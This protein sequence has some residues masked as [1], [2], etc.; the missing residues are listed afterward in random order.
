MKKYVKPAMKVVEL[1]HRTNTVKTM[2]ISI[3]N[4][5]TMAA[6]TLAG[7]IMAG[8][9][10]SDDGIADTP[11]QPENTGK[12]VTLKTTVNLDG[13][14][15]GTRA[16]TSDGVKTF[17]AGETMALAYTVGG[18]TGTKAVS[19]PLEGKDI[20]DDGKTATFTFELTEEPNKTSPPRY[21]YPAAMAKDDGT[22]NYEA[23]YTQ[24][25]GTL[26]TLAKKFDLATGYGEWADDNLTTVTLT[27]DLAILAI[28]L[29]DA[30]IADGNTSN[31]T[32]TITG[33]TISDGTYTYNVT[34]SAA[35]GPIYVAIR[36]TAGATIKVTATDGTNNYVKTLTGKTYEIN[37]G[38]NVS[39]LMT[40]AT[41][42]SET[43]PMTMEALTD[44]NIV[45]NNPQEGM[46][47]SV[48]GGAKIS[49]SSTEN[50]KTITVEAGDRVQFYGMSTSIESYFNVNKWKGT[51][52]TGSGDGFKCKVYG[53]IM[54][55]V[56][57]TGFADATTLTSENTFRWLFH[58]NDK[59]TDAS[60][61]MLPATTLASSCYYGMFSDCTG[62]TAAPALPATEL[63]NYCYY[64]MFSGCSSLT[65][66]PALPAETLANSCY[67]SMFSD[68]T[69]LTTAPA[70]P[71]TELAPHC[72]SG[73]FDGCES[74][75]AAPALPA[76][77]LDER[78]YAHMFSGCSSLTTA[79]ALPAETLYP[80]CY[81]SMFSD[82]TGLTAAPELPATTLAQYCYNGMFEGCYSL[83]AAP[84]LPAETL[85]FNCYNGMFRGCTKLS[86]VTCLAK[87]ISAGD[88]TTDWL[89]DAGREVDLM[90][91]KTF[92]T[93]STT[94]WST[95]FSGIPD[96]WTRLNP[97]GSPYVAPT[98]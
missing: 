25:D 83:T 86:A 51:S 50:P 78:C 57:E 49:I 14:K 75:T 69:G 1:R 10:S 71:A 22:E 54:S 60:G 79:P 19:L 33:L 37:N 58:G 96:G 90:E 20:A 28:N 55:L 45:V 4:Y 16:L 7:A 82:C 31:I 43:T 68:C 65:T 41:P 26:E 97:D 38:Y 93:P 59:L 61:L 13:D 76:E 6:L 21:I 67:E 48:N 32:S 80:S 95:G 53:N 3:K 29:K 87:D 64:E 23:L 8:C 46:Q 39:W 44:G 27:N 89:Q 62:L 70:L 56:D 17:A 88:C 2:N 84:E 77:W 9:S 11:K 94:G 35:A 74:L 63:T 98:Q 24:Q 36:P 73:M 52:I 40:N 34:R 66:A 5:L 18:L 91:E 47:Y 12:V 85:E 42:L 15:A 92:T 30:A 81:D 72:Y